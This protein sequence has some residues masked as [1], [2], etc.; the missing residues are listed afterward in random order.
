[1]VTDLDLQQMIHQFFKIY[2]RMV[3]NIFRQ[4]HKSMPFFCKLKS[5]N[6]MFLAHLV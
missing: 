2:Q 1:M 6:L 5:D 4:N 3:K